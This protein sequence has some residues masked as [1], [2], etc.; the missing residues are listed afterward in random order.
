MPVSSLDTVTRSREVCFLVGS[1]GTILWAEA[2]GSPSALP[3]SRRRWNAIWDRRAELVE[4]AHSHPH[5]P[6]AFSREDETTMAAVQAALGRSVRFSVV[7]P[8]ATVAR[9][10][11]VTRDVFPEPWW[12]AWM[13][14]ASGMP[15]EP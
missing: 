11:G 6:A 14:L 4:I 13:R 9:V 3:D 10:G 5:A 12:A 8:R 15:T 1:R 2:S 7:A